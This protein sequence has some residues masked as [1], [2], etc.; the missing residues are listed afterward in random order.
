MSENS[1]APL[2]GMNGRF[3]MEAAVLLPAHNARALI[4]TVLN[5]TADML[6]AV[7]MAVVIAVE[8][9]DK[10]APINGEN[11]KRQWPLPW[12]GRFLRLPEMRIP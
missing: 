5:P 10:G 9:M 11:N 1:N 7:V 2:A 3:L 4:S 6:E 8:S 12:T